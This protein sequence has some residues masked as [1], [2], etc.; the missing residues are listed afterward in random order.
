M[1][2]NNYLITLFL[3]L[4]FYPNLNAMDDKYTSTNTYYGTEITLDNLLE[5][6]DQEVPLDPEDNFEI[7]N[8]IKEYDLEQILSGAE[9]Q[10]EMFTN[11]NQEERRAIV[12]SITT[13]LEE[14]KIPHINAPNSILIIVNNKW[15]I[16]RSKV[17]VARQNVLDT[18][19]SMRQGRKAWAEWMRLLTREEYNQF[20]NLFGGRVYQNISRAMTYLLARQAA[21]ALDEQNRHNRQHEQLVRIPET[22]LVHIHGRPFDIED[23]NYVVI[24]EY[25]GENLT[26]LEESSLALNEDVTLQMVRMIARTAWWNIRGNAH[27]VDD[28]VNYH[29]HELPNRHDIR[30][31]LHRDTQHYR[32]LVQHGWRDLEENIIKPYAQAHT[33]NIEKLLKHNRDFVQFGWMDLEETIMHYVQEHNDNIERLLACKSALER[34]IMQNWE[35][36]PAVY[37][38]TPDLADMLDLLQFAALPEEHICIIT[39]YV[40]SFTWSALNSVSFL[41][42]C[43]M[44]LQNPKN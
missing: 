29:D 40:R 24:E 22:H 14:R 30:H 9:Y 8:F 43:V 32:D 28:R 21:R 27:L 25:L 2:R 3:L 4:L 42:V 44:L 13:Y 10:E 12:D 38:P 5:L 31:I 37:P 7:Q 41:F 6:L 19:E 1:V 36:A 18:L 23:R 39:N 20:M 16:K 17:H 33:T 11:A 34:E 35:Q 26:P 15:V